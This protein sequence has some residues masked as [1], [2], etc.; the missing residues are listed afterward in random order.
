MRPF[1][2]VLVLLAFGIATL[3]AIL[4]S[5][6]I[7]RKSEPAPVTA[8]AAPSADTVE[9]LVAAGDIKVGAVVNPGDLRYASWPQ[10]AVD[11]RYLRHEN[12]VDPKQQWVGGVA[13]QPLFAGQPITAGA[14][15]HRGEAGVLAGILSPG[16][17]AVAIPVTATSGVAGFVL[18]GDRVDILLDQDVHAATGQADDANSHRNPLRYASEAILTDVKVLAIDEK[19]AKPDGANVASKTVTVEVTPKD[20]ETLVVAGRMGELVLALRGMTQ[21]DAKPAAYMGDVGAS[22]ALR[23][24]LVPGGAF[25]VRVNR[26]GVLTGQA[27]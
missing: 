1:I 7:S 21:D 14:L 9:I 16:M 3:T 19:L 25:G 5:R 4:F 24:A 2:L 11:G 18:A 6:V 8:V 27:F 10:E 23:A 22:K 20:A 12:G 26:G 17:R 15:F 13:R